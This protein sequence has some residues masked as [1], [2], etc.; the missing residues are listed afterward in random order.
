MNSGYH[1]PYG[2]REGVLPIWAHRRAAAP[3][4]GQFPR[5]IFQNRAEGYASRTCDGLDARR[6][7]LPGVQ[8][9]REQRRP[10]RDDVREPVHE[11]QGTHPERCRT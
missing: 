7:F 3:G 8:G 4:A 9:R 10:R 1:W 6:V 5:V 2:R 11:R